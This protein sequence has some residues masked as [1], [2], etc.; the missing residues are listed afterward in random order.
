MLALLKDYWSAVAD[1]FPHAWGLPPRKSRL[2]HGVGIVAMGFLLDAIAD[3]YTTKEPPD[4]DDFVLHLAPLKPVCKWTSGEWRFGRRTRRRWNEIQN[5]AKDIELLA[6]Y[7]LTQ[8]L[9]RVWDRR[10]AAG[11]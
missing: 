6:D 11:G 5:T 10:Q 9:E 7:L 2:M 1:T 4:K 3:G 8:F